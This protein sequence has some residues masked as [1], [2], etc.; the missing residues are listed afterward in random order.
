MPKLNLADTLSIAILPLHTVSGDQYKIS[1]RKYW[2]AWH[3]LIPWRNRAL[4]K[5]FSIKMHHKVSV[6]LGQALLTSHI[7]TLFLSCYQA[8]IK[9]H[10]INRDWCPDLTEGFVIPGLAWGQHFF[11]QSN[12]SCER[13]TCCIQFR[14]LISL[15][16]SSPQKPPVHCTLTPSLPCWFPLVIRSLELLQWNQSISVISIDKVTKLPCELMLCSRVSLIGY[17][18]FVFWAKDTGAVGLERS[19]NTQRQRTKPGEKCKIFYCISPKN[20]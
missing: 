7:S 11:F 17:G 8:A 6:T 9:L 18:T 13:C 3:F 19:S 4:H 2:L 16:T 20:C 15:Y 14:Y 5:L 12:V 1:N 10:C